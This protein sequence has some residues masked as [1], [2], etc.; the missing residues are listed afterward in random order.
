M[1]ID[2]SNGKNKG[3]LIRNQFKR[4]FNQFGES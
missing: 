2:A 3:K 1:K 4:F